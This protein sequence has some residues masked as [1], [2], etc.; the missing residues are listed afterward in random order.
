M[1]QASQLPPLQQHEQREPQALQGQQQ[2]AAAAGIAAAP[3]AMNAA[4]GAAASSAAEDAPTVLPTLVVE[5]VGDSLEVVCITLPLGRDRVEGEL[6]I[7]F[8]S[9]FGFKVCV[10]TQ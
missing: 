9:I 1:Q 6:G 8:H 10:V 2:P 3:A 5:V 7:H 4:A